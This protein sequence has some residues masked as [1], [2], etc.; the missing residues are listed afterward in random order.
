MCGKVG[1]FAPIEHKLSASLIFPTGAD[2]LLIALLMRLTSKE[3]NQ[4]AP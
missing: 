2:D 4:P 3:I 1:K